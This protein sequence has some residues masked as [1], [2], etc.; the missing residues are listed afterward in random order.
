MKPRRILFAAD[1]HYDSHAGKHICGALSGDFEIVFCE[2]DWS[3]FTNLDLA[4][5]YDLV[6]LHMIADT[7]GNPR[8]DAAVEEQIKAYCERG[9]DLLLLHGSSAAFWHWDWW[10]RIV[11]L[12]WV[13]GNDPDGVPPSTHPTRPYKVDVVA[14]S[15]PLSSRL[16]PL[17]LPADELYI[18]LQEVSPVTVLMETSTD[19]GLF[20]Q[21]YE[22]TTPWGGRIIGFIP[23]HC[24]EV[25]T[26]PDLVFNVN[27][28]IEYL[29]AAPEENPRASCLAGGIR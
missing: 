2:N 18:N 17:D 23:G 29:L 9:K 4:E 15:H 16:K 20:P 21:C 28:L 19:E 7:C 27:T 8:P 10:R 1:D 26:H 13:R 6:I 3:A 14:S 11:G 12:R 5:T 24:R 25:T 22:C